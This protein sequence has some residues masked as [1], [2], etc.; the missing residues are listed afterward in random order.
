M[1]DREAIAADVGAAF[2]SQVR[3]FVS[4]DS[5]EE[6]AAARPG[7]HA[8]ELG[9]LQEAADRLHRS[10]WSAIGAVRSSAP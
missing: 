1:T 9:E 3:H 4:G 7:C 2:C 10:I 6:F 5:A 8:V